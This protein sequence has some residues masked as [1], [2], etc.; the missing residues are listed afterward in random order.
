MYLS[1]QLLNFVVLQLH[2][3]LGKMRKEAQNEF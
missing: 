3:V 1:Q 2:S